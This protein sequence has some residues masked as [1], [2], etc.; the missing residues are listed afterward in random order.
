MPP[1]TMIMKKAITDTFKSIKDD[2][3]DNPLPEEMEL[4]EIKQ[5][6]IVE[7]AEVVGYE[8][9][10]A[11]TQKSNILPQN[12]II[13]LLKQS[14]QEEESMKQWYRENTLLAIDKLWPNI[15]SAFVKS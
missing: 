9:L 10:I 12:D 11:I 6:A 3:T 5:D 14:L 1:T 13:P 4:M 8:A 15:K 7:G 2:K